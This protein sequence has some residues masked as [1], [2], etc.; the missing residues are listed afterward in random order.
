[1]RINQIANN[2]VVVTHDRKAFYFSYEIPI[3]KV[4]GPG[5]AGEV[6]ICPDFANLSKTSMKWLYVFL[7]DYS[8]INPAYCNKK[9]L[10]ALMKTGEVQMLKGEE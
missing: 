8:C 6:F 4:E 7:Q 3:A 10:Q 2:Q 1:M 9:G 5:R